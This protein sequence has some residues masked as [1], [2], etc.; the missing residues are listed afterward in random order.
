MFSDQLVSTTTTIGTL[1]CPV[2]I[3]DV[4]KYMPLDDVLIGLK[5]VYARGSATILRGVARVPKVRK[6]KNREGFYRDFYN[7]VTCTIRLPTQTNGQIVTLVSCKV[8]H[9]GTLHITGS[10]NRT[11]ATLAANYLVPRLAALHGAKTAKIKP[12]CRYL[13][14]YDNLIYATDGQVIGWS[15]SGLA[16]VH[17]EF[18]TVIALADILSQPQEQDQDQE[19]EPVN[20]FV[21]D[22]WQECRKSV[23]SLNG[24]KLGHLQL[25]FE[26]EATRR[27]F[28][29]K[30][31]YIYSGHNI[32]G[33]ETFVPCIEPDKFQEHILKERQERQYLLD[34]RLIVRVFSA[35]PVEFARDT[36]LMEESFQVH[37]INTFFQAPI[38][39][40]RDR[41]HQCFLENGY[42]SRLEPCDNAAVNL[43]YHHN[44]AT[45]HDNE[46]RGKCAVQNKQACTCKDIS[47]SCFN[48]GKMNVA[49][50]ANMEQANF[51]YDFLQTFFSK[52]RREI[53]A[54]PMV[55]DS[56]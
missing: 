23:Y 8:F 55:V 48:S 17:S 22:K 39:I 15:T 32:V 6:K 11:E 3:I 26:P 10:H 16:H 21:S 29:V 30:F 1:G 33:K 5:L 54:T 14:S 36:V 42:Y 35:L 20:V 52:H 43:R 47:V 41:L 40:N 18:V 7:Q 4:A 50:L 44:V 13:K 34:N 51:V 27:H 12:D 31:G 46:R 28:E 38:R 56:T 49:G 37:M 53:E 9:N 24:H 19:Q 2:N 45:Q 25:C